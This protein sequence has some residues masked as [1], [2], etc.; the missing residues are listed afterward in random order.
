[1]AISFV[2]AGAVGTGTSATATVPAGVVAGD[3]LLLTTTSGGTASTPAGWTALTTSVANTRECVFYKVAGS[4]ET[5]VITSNLQANGSAVM[6]AYRGVGGIAAVATQ[7]TGTGTTATPGTV[8]TLFNNSW[9]VNVYTCATPAA[10]WTAN[11]STTSRLNS[12][13]TASNYG[14]LV[15]DENQAVAGVSTARAATLSASVVWAT[16]VIALNPD[17]TLYWVG[18]TAAWDGTAGTKWALTSGGGGGERIPTFGDAVFFDAAS[19]VST[20]S[21][22]TGNTGAKSITC[23][24]F[25]GTL[26]GFAPISLYGNLT[27]VAGMIYTYANAIAFLSD[28]VL[29]TA[30][31]NLLDITLNNYASV[32]SLA[33]P[34]SLPNHTLSV[35]AGTFNTNNFSLSV[36]LFS[37]LG[38]QPRTINLGSSAVTVNAT[39]TAINF[40]TGLVL[41]AGTS[42][43]SLTGGQPSLTASGLTFYNVTFTTT[44]PSSTININGSNTF[45][46]LTFAG[47]NSNSSIYNVDFSGNITVNGTLSLNANSPSATGRMRISSNSF[48]VTRTFTCAAIAAMRD[49]D[50]RDIT[51]T[52]AAAPLSGTRL[53][54]GGG[55]SGIT[56][57]AGVNKYWNLAGGGTWGSSTA[58]A[59]TSGGTPALSNFPLPQDNCIFEATGLNSG[60]T[61][62]MGDGWWFNTIDMS[63]RTTNTMTLSLSSAQPNVSGDW[64]NGTGV[65]I[66]GTSLSILFTGRATQTITSAGRTFT[67]KAINI[68]SAGTVNLADDLVCISNFGFTVTSGTFNTNNFSLTTTNFGSTNSNIRTI[69]FGTS[70]IN[71]TGTGTIWGFGTT[72]N[73]TYNGASA[74]INL[75]DT[76]T[77]ARTFIGG[78]ITY[79]TLNIGGTTGSST[80]NLQGNGTT[81]NNIT[82][83]KTV[84]H[85]ISIDITST[86]INFNNFN[87]S[88]SAGNL[89]SITG[90]SNTFSIFNYTGSGVVSVDYINYSSGLFAPAASATGATPYVWYL[91]TNSI[92]NF[93]SNTRAAFIDGTT[94]RAYAITSGT[95]WTTPADWNSGANTIYMIGGGAGGVTAGSGN[96]GPGGGGGGFTQVSNFSASPSTAIPLV[97]GAGGTN[98]TTVGGSAGS[99][100]FGDASPGTISFVDS[101]TLA[102]TAN[103]TSHVMNVPTGTANYDLMV[104]FYTSA[105]TS[106]QTLPAGW[107][108]AI[109]NTATGF[110][111]YKVAYSEP[112]SYTVTT[113][114]STIGT[115]YIVTYRNAILDT[116]GSFSASA[117]PSV[118]SSITVGF[119]NSLVLDYVFTKVGS[120]TYTTP[121]GFSSVASESNANS[122]SS[123]LFSK[124]FNAGATGT[125]S[126]TPSGGNT[127]QSVL[128]SL[129][130]A[131]PYAAYG[132][133]GGS[134]SGGGAGGTGSTYNGGAGGGVGT[135]SSGGGGGAGGP[136]GVGAAGGPGVATG[137]GGG[138]GNGGGSVGGT[139]TAGVGGTGGNNFAGTGGGAVNTAG[140]NGGGGGG[141]STAGAGG[142]GGGGLDI[143]NTV[144]S[145]G[146]A[147]A[148]GGAL[149]QTANGGFYGGGKGGTS[150]SGAV[151]GSGRQGVIFIIY[152]PGGTAFTA[153]ITE[154][155]TFADVSDALIAITGSVI[156]GLGVADTAD[157]VTAFA[158][159]IVE[160]VDVAD[161]NDVL[162]ALNA[163]V[164]E[165]L[166]VADAQNAA[167]TLNVSITEEILAAEID[168]FLVITFS[169]VV[170]EALTVTDI[171]SVIAA[172]AAAIA[173]NTTLADTPTANAAFN[174]TATEPITVEDA[175]TVVASFIGVIT[176]DTQIADTPSAVASF[177]AA[178]VEAAQLADVQSVVLVLNAN[179][180]EAITLAD[181]HTG[182]VT[183]ANVIF[184]GINVAD[185][186]SV[187]ASFAAVITEDTNLQDLQE[188][189]A[190]FVSSLVEALTAEDSSI[191]IKIHNSDITEN[192]TLADTQTVV[193]AFAGLVL[194]NLNLA[195][196]PTVIASFTSQITENLVLLDEPFPRGWLKINDTQNGVWAAINNAESSTWTSINDGQ[197][198]T[199][200]PVNNNYP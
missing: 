112:A 29:T 27:L 78:G 19:G 185:S 197:T 108:S 137:G 126:T 192:V 168:N 42:A 105:A 113:V 79:G 143:F 145:G 26:A 7:T 187:I 154:G 183:F 191:G 176:E 82:S 151:S 52:G 21:I 13:S 62:N 3:V 139:G 123:A 102:E 94:Q 1:M 158:S 5:S 178:I 107:T 144:G 36:N 194:E 50:F 10:T 16:T 97:I 86:T 173:E 9:L 96:T 198:V 182:L 138:G 20:V 148:A 128:V 159:A 142:S 101:T 99:T 110:V 59:L 72:T 95:S 186:Q 12:A 167:S 23:T 141:F 48:G 165:A 49:V 190:A 199:W 98:A 146:G 11:G 24:G 106:T 32:F 171:E 181:S 88:G 76:T 77:T 71:L 172:F 55:N 200:V 4:A 129:R 37:A 31:K 193:A 140:T 150:S 155:S 81:F 45:N 25:T 75:T 118:A 114:T 51:I 33:D 163:A 90:A 134:A 63:A 41:N 104:M 127:G 18:G 44:N 120:V 28:A 152:T 35:T 69:N 103:T 160:N 73:L 91:G 195:D 17:R 196:A 125:V 60:A 8:T 122:P 166:S 68:T 177:A 157:V 161:V 22:S 53:G 58:W 39:S 164:S 92:N 85:T 66:S 43:I 179:I 56:F 84:A 117:T 83:T 184:E 100:Y 111:A 40:A 15:A 34:C 116:N 89:V 64:I 80:L 174:G 47:D 169:G 38:A 6:V 121:T 57:A 119:D 93:G 175:E 124:S 130:A 67:S 14:I 133:R 136:N 30:G 153:S 135:N 87:V 180:T 156:E 162:A 61:V 74:T 131:P 170:S 189:T 147:G 149:S 188:V 54:D 109:A 2:G 65:T 132:G 70:T 115:G 46:N